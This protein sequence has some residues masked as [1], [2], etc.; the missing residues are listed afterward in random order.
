MEVLSLFNSDTCPKSSVDV[1]NKLQ[2]HPELIDHI[3]RVN[4]IFDNYYDAKDMV[5]KVMEEES[6]IIAGIIQ[7][8]GQR[9]AVYFRGRQH[10]E[11]RRGCFIRFVDKIKPR[12]NVDLFIKIVC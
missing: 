7:R 8:K 10:G 3:Q 4:P 1:L 5:L 12:N 11:T 6:D 9:C 2:N